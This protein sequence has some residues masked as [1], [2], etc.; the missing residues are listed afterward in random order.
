[1]M[2]E[3]K[4]SS[5]FGVVHFLTLS[6]ETRYISRIPGRFAAQ[7]QIVPIFMCQISIKRRKAQYLS[8]AGQNEFR[9]VYVVICCYYI[10]C[11]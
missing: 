5:P 4:F 3:E 2:K 8:H 10:L 7:K 11:S 1:M 6:P 9:S